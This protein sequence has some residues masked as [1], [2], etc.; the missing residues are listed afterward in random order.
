[1]ESS[2]SGL[3]TIFS[4]IHSRDMFNRDRHLFF[5]S[6]VRNQAGVNFE[7]GLFSVAAKQTSMTNGFFIVYKKQTE[8]QV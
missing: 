4:R 5:F 1:M 7:K 6:G 3:F 8:E 2:P